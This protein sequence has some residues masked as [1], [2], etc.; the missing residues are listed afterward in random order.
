MSTLTTQRLTVNNITDKDME[1][2]ANLARDIEEEEF[3]NLTWR[4]IDKDVAW[5]KNNLT[6]SNMAIIVVRDDKKIIGSGILTTFTGHKV[7]TFNN[8]ITMEL[9][10]LNTFKNKGYISYVYIDKEYRGHKIGY[11]IMSTLINSAKD[12]FKSVILQVK[13]PIAKNLYT[14]LGFK[15]YK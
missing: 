2:I 7:H 9:K 13:N 14:K 10:F 5:I 1:D 15:K 12:S 11:D 3:D 6:D 4:S 8:C